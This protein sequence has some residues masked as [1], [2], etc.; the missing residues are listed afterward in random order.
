M[1]S[2]RAGAAALDI[3]PPFGLP[4]CGV[5][6]RDWTGTA[7]IGKLEV[8]A[9]A[10]EIDG[11]RAVVCG[12]DTLAL[13]SPEI[14]ETRARVAAATGAPLASVL[15][16]AS[17]T[18][19]APPTSRFFSSP[20]G[21]VDV[22][23][24][25]A[26][27]AHV[28]YVHDQ[29]V[30]VCELAFERLEPAWTRWGLGY[31][32]FA[33]NRRERDPD[34]RVRRL[35]WNE[36][37]MLD[38][39]VPVL[40]AVRADESAIGTLVA[41]GAHTVTTW[42]ESNAYSP[43]Y[44]GAL[45]DAVRR[46]TGGECVFLIG[47][48]GNVMPRI[49]FEQ[50]GRAMR[51]M[52]EGVALA[53]LS[54]LGSRPTWPSEL[55]VGSGFRSGNAVAAYRWRLRDAEPPPLRAA[56]RVVSFPL[57]PLPLLDEIVE[58]RERSERE[59]AEAI[60]RGAAEWELR[61]LRYHGLAY[62]LRT[63]A[64][65]R[66]GSA[67]TAVEGPV[68]ALRIGDGVIAT[69]PGEIFTEIGMAVKERSPADVTLYAGCVNETLSY[70]PTASEFPLGGY[71][72][73]YGNKTYGLPIQVDPSCDRLLVETAVGLVRDLFPDRAGGEDGDWTA[74]GKLPQVPP[75]PPPLHRPEAA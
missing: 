67:P 28:E 47:A 5:V 16:G 44:P 75:A 10:F 71:E 69:G 13:Q 4:M 15:I 6:A 72:P 12:V 36:E 59:V 50:T 29:I 25:P 31:A 52:G 17:H 65:L 39:S 1:S 55:S 51:E 34:G 26:T 64:E 41:Y 45:R 19:H 11:A 53:A 63:E 43:D 22:P 24:D 38:Q 3:D 74:S 14:G 20:L 73:D 66:S 35:G 40:Q 62:A 8:T 42:I 37:G 56:E 27:L 68:N 70:F 9:L 46:W 60:E 54:A 32:D 61:G 30:A 18:H 57:Q 21:T 2:F 33:I 23:A 7:R 48:A 49:S 58:L